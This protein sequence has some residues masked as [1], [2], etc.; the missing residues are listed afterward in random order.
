MQ[1][2]GT[3][4]ELALVTGANRGLGLEIAR[5]LAR[6]GYRVAL[7]ARSRQK[8]E[9][10]AALLASEGLGTFPIAL[11]VDDPNSV[12]DAVSALTEEHGDIGILVNNAGVFLDGPD[13]QTASV[14]DLPPERLLASFRTNTMGALLTM[15]AVLPAM[16]RR[17]FGRIVNV[18]S[19]AG[20]LAE[21]RPGV[22]SYR[23]TKTALNSLTRVSAAE[24][25]D[26]DIKINAMCPGW[27]RTAMGGENA[28]L[29]VE[30]GAV[31]AVWLATLPPNGPTGG[32]FRSRSALA[33]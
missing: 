32:F 9:R 27:I 23:I 21:L 19:R 33:W 17:G 1:H 18:S 8:G 20:Q 16:R 15:Q 12:R 22:P 28:P 2:G 5:Q 11:D 31:T 13:P 26:L 3:T 30:E 4:S 24:F 6:L 7:S 14:L 25:K 10:A 29:S